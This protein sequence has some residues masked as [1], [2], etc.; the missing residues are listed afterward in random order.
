MALLPC[1]ES[2]SRR[3]RRLQDTAAHRQTATY[4][5]DVPIKVDI[6]E[7]SY[8]LSVNFVDDQRLVLAQGEIARLGLWFTN[9]GTKPITEVWM[10]AGTD[11]EV[12]VEDTKGDSEGKKYQGLA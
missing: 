11:D 4:A 1:T 12:W 3:G 10:V 6:V 8:K 7:A 5:A 9:T 2:L